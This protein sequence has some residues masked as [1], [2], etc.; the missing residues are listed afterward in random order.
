MSV[1][2]R[3]KCSLMALKVYDTCVLSGPLTTEQMAD[4]LGVSYNYACMCVRAAQRAGILKPGGRRKTEGRGAVIWLPA[5]IVWSRGFGEEPPNQAKWA[6]EPTKENLPAYTRRVY[7]W[8][9]SEDPTGMTGKTE[10]EIRKQF[11]SFGVTLPNVFNQLVERD[12]AKSW[13]DLDGVWRWSISDR[14]S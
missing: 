8:L 1:Y 11:V 9:R 14:L 13:Q 12:L 2:I 10:K 6:M 3:S 5:D 4:A 7:E